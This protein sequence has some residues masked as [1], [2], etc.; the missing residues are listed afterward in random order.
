MMAA[1][2]TMHSVLEKTVLGF[3]GHVAWQASGLREGEAALKA[4]AKG[5]R[6]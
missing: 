2:E 5:R 1:R 6:Q 4:L 3:F